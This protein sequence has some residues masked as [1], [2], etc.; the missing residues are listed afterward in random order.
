MTIA[1][2]GHK[3]ETVPARARRVLIAVNLRAG[4]G[5]RQKTIAELT[6]ALA[7]RN[8]DCEVFHSLDQLAKSAETAFSAGELRAAVAAGGDGTAAEVANRIPYGAPLAVFPLGTENLLANLLHMT[9]NPAQLC[10]VL[11]LGQMMH[12]DAGCANG[13]LFL[14]MASIGFDAEVVRILHDT[15]SGNISRW[16]YVKPILQSIGRYRFPEL[17]I[18]GEMKRDVPGEQPM[19]E[20]IRSRWAFVFNVSRYGF[21]LKFVPAADYTDGLLDV[22]TFR[23]GGLWSGLKYLTAV[24]RQSHHASSHCSVRRAARIR[25]EADEPVPYQ[26]DGDPGGVLPVDIKVLQSRLRILV[27]PANFASNS[28]PTANSATVAGSGTV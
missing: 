19:F 18:L 23:R 25:I 9:H 24:L 7:A 4:D 2:T 1:M 15:R 21:N 16:T 10:N 6:A 27:D 17:R 26:I 11:E 3:F 8:F 22:I 5:S 20:T 28:A 13:R 12:L 14:L